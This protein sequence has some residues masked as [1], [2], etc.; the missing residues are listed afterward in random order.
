MTGGSEVEIERP[1]E[2]YSN[3]ELIEYR[4]KTWEGMTRL[5]DDPADT[6]PGNLRTTSFIGAYKELGPERIEPL[7]EILQRHPLV[8]LGGGL[9]GWPDE[10]LDTFGIPSYTNVDL[11]NRP[12]MDEMPETRRKNRPQD[13]L[14]ALLE[15]P[16]DQKVNVTSN[17]V[18]MGDWFPFA[19]HPEWYKILQVSGVAFIQKGHTSIDSSK[20]FIKYFLTMEFLWLVLTNFMLLQNKTDYCSIMN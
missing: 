11:Q 20:L 9:G 7:K 19:A 18:L 17:G 16:D 15:I 8:D 14:E 10:L 12:V 6:T 4:R 3:E 2:S 5:D 1:P 13:L